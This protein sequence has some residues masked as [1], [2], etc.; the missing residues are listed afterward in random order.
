MRRQVNRYGLSFSTVIF[1]TGLTLPAFAQ[2]YVGPGAGLSLLAALWGLVVAIGVAVI[3][4]IMWPIRRMRR[5]KAAAQAAASQASSEAA[6]KT[7]PSSVQ[8]NTDA[9]MAP[10]NESDPSQPGN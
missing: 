6:Q 3:F 4:F 10:S 5:R 9:R 1:I 2:A 7:S 8:Q